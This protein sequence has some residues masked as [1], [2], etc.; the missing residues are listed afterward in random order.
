MSVIATLYFAGS[1]H[2]KEHQDDAIV[3]AYNLTTGPAVFFPGP[4]GKDTSI[5]SKNSV[6]GS[7]REA[8]LGQ[9][10]KSSTFSSATKRGMTGKGWNRNIWFALQYIAGLIQNNPGQ[11]TINFAGHSRGSITI[12]MLLN[13]ILHEHVPV[14]E[15]AGF[16]IASTITGTKTYGDR[17]GS[18]NDWYENRL[19]KTFTKRMGSSEDADLGIQYLRTVCANKARLEFNVWM[20]DPVGGLNQGHSSRKQEFPEH[21]KIKRVRVMRMETGGAGGTLS[22]NMPTFRGRPGWEFLGGDRKRNLNQYAQKERL[23]IPMPGTHG[24]GLSHNGGDSEMQQYIGR[25]YM[26][27]LLRACGTTFEDDLFGTSDSRFVKRNYDMLMAQFKDKKP[28]GGR[29]NMH[30]HH[31]FE[32]V[33]FTRKTVGTYLGGAVNAHHRYL[34]ELH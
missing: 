18:F 23:V 19:H 7:G 15:Q 33:G 22:T 27:G 25:S 28:E 32:T 4:G 9:N 14:S 26:V 29:K 30:Y 1:G 5:Y 21:D 11:I 20:F 16:E 24:A 6:V 31:T 17:S 13:D 2:G 3:D 34:Q 8:V 12:I 10:Y